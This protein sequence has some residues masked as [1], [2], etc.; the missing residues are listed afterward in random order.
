MSKMIKT[1]G[2]VLVMAGSALFAHDGIEQN[3]DLKFIRDWMKQQ[4]LSALADVLQLTDEQIATLKS[5]R[6]AVDAVTEEYAPRVEETRAASEA[7]F[8]EVRTNIETT[9]TMTEE[10]EAALKEARQSLKL[11]RKEIRTRAAAEMVVLEGLLTDEQLAALRE[12]FKNNRGDEQGKRAKQGRG[13]GQA[14]AAADRGRGGNRGSRGA[15]LMRVLI[16]EEF[17]ALL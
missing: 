16:S 17:L 9:D 2:L 14:N 4:Q 10:D 7:V 3:E 8:A 11:L 13:Q 1:L 5:V 15:R 6:A 12:H